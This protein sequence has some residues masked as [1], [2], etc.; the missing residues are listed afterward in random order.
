MLKNSQP[1]SGLSCLCVE[2]YQE[3][4][5]QGDADNLRWF[6]GGAEALLEGDEVRFVAPHHAG[7][8]E[9]DFADCGAASAHRALALMLA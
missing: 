6:A 8:D 7:H 5:C 2:P 1:L 9:Q 3:L 4:V